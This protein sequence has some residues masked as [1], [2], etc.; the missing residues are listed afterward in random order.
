VVHVQSNVHLCIIEVDE[1]LVAKE[2]KSLY[3]P[4]QSVLTERL[5]S[6]NEEHKVFFVQASYTAIRFVSIS[7]K[8]GICTVVGLNGYLLS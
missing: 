4:M 6:L 1:L 2:D 8:L 3:T 7:A 5:T